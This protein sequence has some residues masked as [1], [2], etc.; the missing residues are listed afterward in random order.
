[1]SS[2]LV[3][4]AAT[5][6][7]GRRNNQDAVVVGDGL[8]GLADGV[9]GLSSG[10]VAS[11][12]ALDA[13]NADFATDRSSAGLLHACQQ[14]NRAVLRRADREAVTMGTTLVA[15]AMT[16]DAGVVAAHVGDSRLYRLRNGNLELL[17]RDHTVIA[18]LLRAGAVSEDAADEH[19]HRNVLTRAIGVG[20]EVEVDRIE[21]SCLPGDRL[22]ICSDGL[23][24]TLSTEEIEEILGSEPN[25]QDAAEQLVEA[26]VEQHSDDNVSAVV[27]NAE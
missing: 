9:G 14:A 23:F 21:L 13:L 6:Q 20:P 1:M 15:V 12:L 7:G 4:G 22:L 25:P 26:A 18:E 3:A 16:T 17:T 27:V 11:R 5:H 10:E 8:F 24:K 19:P 2:T